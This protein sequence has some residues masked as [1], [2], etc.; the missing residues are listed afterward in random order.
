LP[1]GRCWFVMRFMASFHR[2]CSVARWWLRA[3]W[4]KPSFPPI[5]GLCTERGLPLGCEIAGR[6]LWSRP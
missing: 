3:K 6:R 1:F 2:G 4:R 5:D